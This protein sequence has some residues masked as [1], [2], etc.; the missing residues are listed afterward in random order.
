MVN[1][2]AYIILSMTMSTDIDYMMFGCKKA[3]KLG[4]I[5]ITGSPCAGC[6]N[7]AL[8]KKRCQFFLVLSGESGARACYG[9]K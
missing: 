3:S 4:K 5:K 6:I 7:K 9:I 2:T 8:Q 1:I